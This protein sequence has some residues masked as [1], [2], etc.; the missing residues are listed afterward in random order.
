MFNGTIFEKPKDMEDAVRMITMLSGQ[1]H[2][3]VTGVAVIDTETEEKVVDSVIS[4]VKFRELTKEEIQSYVN[5][6]EPLIK[7]GA[8]NANGGAKDFIEEIQGSKT[9]VYGL[10][11]E[12]VSEILKSMTSSE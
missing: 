3:V 6:G 5:T 4:K 8:Y 11:M 1:W 10:P 7:A 12:R 9:S 2:E